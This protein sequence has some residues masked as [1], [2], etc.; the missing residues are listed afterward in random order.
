MKKKILSMVAAVLLTANVYAQNYTAQQKR[1]LSEISSY[2]SKAGY[3]VEE[4]ENGL[5]FKDD[6]A[7]Y[8]VEMSQEDTNP[9]FVRICRYVPFKSTLKKEVVKENIVDLNSTYGIKTI[10]RDNE[11]L[12]A[13][14]MFLTKASQLTN[15]F[16]T[17]MKEFSYVYEELTEQ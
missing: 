6:G 10:I 2:V 1:V 15:V 12:L 7:V 9:L 16:H 5:K 14:D 4:K 3:S 13:S 17:I 8:Y 11:V